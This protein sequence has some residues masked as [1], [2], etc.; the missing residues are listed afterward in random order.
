[1]NFI[2]S[3]PQSDYLS[4]ALITAEERKS[5]LER[6]THL[7]DDLTIDYSDDNL[8]FYDLDRQIDDFSVKEAKDLLENAVATDDFDEE[9]LKNNKFLE[10]SYKKMINA[11]SL[12][13]DWFDDFE[14][15]IEIQ[16][17]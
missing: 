8:P 5:Y 11:K 4:E 7:D 17:S 15:V 12:I 6:L 2:V 9:K 10:K 14:K 13:D 3:V 16:N 1:M